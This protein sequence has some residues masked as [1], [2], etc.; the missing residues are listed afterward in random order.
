MGF[1]DLMADGDG[2][3]LSI[4]GAAVTYTP[5]TGAAVTVTGIFDAAYSRVDAGMPGISS[6]GPAVFLQLSD[7][8]ALD[9]VVDSGA[10]VTVS[11]TT[12]TVHEAL[13]DGLGVI[14]LRLHR[15]A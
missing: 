15:A 11:G 6:S 5:T 10:T 8:G 14:I 12:Y 7:L 3:I 4:L 1:A 9:P 13:P 2:L